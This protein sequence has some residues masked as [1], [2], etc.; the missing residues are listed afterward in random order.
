MRAEIVVHGATKEQKKIV[1][2]VAGFMANELFPR[3]KVFIDFN[4]KKL[5]GVMGYCDYKYNNY[6]P[7]DFQIEIEKTLSNELLI[8]TIIHEMIHIEQMVT[9]KLKYRYD[10]SFELKQLWYD[11]DFSNAEYSKQPWEKD[12]YKKEIIYAKKLAKAIAS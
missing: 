9:E 3:H 11:K 8:E 1:Y 2:M 6:R 10:K 4:F 7:R 5:D 12:A